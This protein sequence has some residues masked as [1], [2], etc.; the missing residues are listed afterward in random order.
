MNKAEFRAMREMVGMTQAT[1]ADALGVE[2]RSVKR[3]ESPSAPQVPPEEAW[4]VLRHAVAM[5]RQVVDFML[6]KA[7][8][9]EDAPVSIRYWAS[10]GDYDAERADGGDW[11]MAN[12]NVRAAA[13]V[14]LAEGR[15]VE[16]RDG[17]LA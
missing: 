17:P 10:Q 8:E 7:D 3:W 1:L 11:R 5:Q 4:G 16:W 6:G 13:S 9:H 12:A 2:V 14:L 15:V